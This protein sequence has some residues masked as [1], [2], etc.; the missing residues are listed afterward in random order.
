[1]THLHIHPIPAFADNYIWALH[2]DH[3]CVVVDPG[4][5]PPV[6]EWLG[7]TGL[8]LTA[9][10]ITHHHADHVGGIE[11]LRRRYSTVPVYGPAKETIP[12][13]THPLVEGDR[14]SVPSPALSFRIWE[15]PGH[16]LGHIAYIADGFALVGDTLFAA[17][18]G[19]L[20]EGTPAQML[21]SLSRLAAL[22]ESTQIYCTH[23]YT[24][25]NLRFAL[26]ADGDNAA[27]IQRSFDDQATRDANQ[28]TIPTSVAIERATNPFLRAHLPALQQSA[29]RQSGQALSSPL[30]V[31]TALREW[32]N[33]FR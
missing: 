11:E 2:N 12:K 30:D 18:C 8:S 7:R 33:H 23:E 20:F 14:V 1:M 17:G 32:K 19:R 13:C 22:P 10:L 28:P 9:I 15:I 3:A 6:L 27:L 16:T 5:A 21:H 24:L 31:F 29:S 4:D 26:A 25:S